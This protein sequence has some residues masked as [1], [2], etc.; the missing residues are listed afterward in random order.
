MVSNEAWRDVVNYEGF[1]QVSD[2]GRVRSLAH[3]QGKWDS[4]YER[5]F[6]KILK[7]TKDKD[8]YLSVILCKK[9]KI[10]KF[11]VHRL[12]A[13]AFI[14][15]PSNLPLINHKDQ[16]KQNN[17][18]NNLEWCTAK[19]N[20]NYGN[21]LQRSGEKRRNTPS[22]SKP[23]IMI[24]DDGKS[25]TFPSMNEAVRTLNISWKRIRKSI[26]ENSNII[27]N[28]FKFKYL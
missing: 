14:K 20:V 11:R 4:V 7:Q 27:N 19:Y 16:D 24:Y 9:G 5:R 15:N 1:Y 26:K 25:R 3:Y 13:M 17:N 2:E 6:P 8:G 28:N 10:Q 23:I 18:V 21:S 12:V 22:L